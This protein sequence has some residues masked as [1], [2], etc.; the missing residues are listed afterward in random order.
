MFIGASPGSTGGGIKTST[1]AVL[2]SNLWATLR[3]RTRV[4]ALHRTIPNETVRRALAVTSMAVLSVAILILALAITEQARF[5]AR[6]ASKRIAFEDVCFEAFSA[7][8]TVGLS[9]GIT[10]DLSTAGRLVICVGMF[11]GRIGP[12]TLAVAMYGQARR[13]RYEY[14][15]EGVMIG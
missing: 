2:F 14:P 13:G 11:V 8:G 15:E 12:L 4:E 9:R 10:R 1:V 6:D 7:F 5:T 3:R